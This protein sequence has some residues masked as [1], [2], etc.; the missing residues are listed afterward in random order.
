MTFASPVFLGIS[1]LLAGASPVAAKSA[2]PSV[3]GQGDLLISNVT[4]IDTERGRRVPRQDVAIKDGRILFVARSGSRRF[5]AA[6]V[7]DG[8]G[9]YVM[10]GLFDMHT[11]SSFRPV[12]LATL[13]LMTANGVTGI[14]EMGSDCVKPG[15]IGMCID[16]MR[17]AQAKIE[18]GELVGP[19]IVE[20]SSAKVSGNRPKDATP[21]QAAYT[22]ANA[23]DARAAAAILAGRGVDLVK[24]SEE[25]SPD[26]FAALVAEAG[27]RKLK[28]GG[29]IPYKFSV[30]DVAAMGFTSIEHARDLPLDCSRFGAD[31]RSKL[32][33]DAASG[34]ERKFDR[35]TVPGKARDGFDPALCRRQIAAMVAHRTYYVPTHVTREMDYRAGEAAYRNDPRLDYVT[36]FQKRNWNRD[37]D[38]TASA[39]PVLVKDLTD[40]FQLGLKTTKMAHDAG[41]RV[42]AGTDAN[43]TMIFPG[44][45]LHDELR[46]LVAAGLTPMEALQSAT[47]VPAQYLG[48]TK[49]FGGVSSGK[50]ADLLLLSSDPT[51]DIAN[52]K[53]IVAVVQGGRVRDRAELDRLLDEVRLWVKQADAQAGQR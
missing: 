35:K 4:V 36:A 28:T 49:D 51:A 17:A 52:S 7:I 6:S 31:I 15:P 26:A 19:R 3:G 41:V 5:A 18:A 44:F 30:S 50:L 32:A 25:L 29:H 48:R 16:E 45:S 43:D 20:L 12:H 14:R 13:K 33:A 53:A 47:S 10:P 39:P 34:E 2:S 42:M 46:H 8:R 11:H 23:D 21:E 1:A 40:F 27:K 22:P 38:R 9:K 37:L 24:T